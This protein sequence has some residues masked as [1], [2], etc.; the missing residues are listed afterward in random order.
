MERHKPISR[1]PVAVC[2]QS[3]PVQAKEEPRL[4]NFPPSVKLVYLT[5]T[6]EG[7]LTQ[8]ELVEQTE[9]AS[10]TV[11]SALSDLVDAGFVS[12]ELYLQD[13]RQ[14]KYVA[15]ETENG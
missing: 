5:L 1:S 11:R 4:G 2:C 10:R 13:L 14:R 12:E 3:T 8:K 9:L 7:P 6:Y 15:L